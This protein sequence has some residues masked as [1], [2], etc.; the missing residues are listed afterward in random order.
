MN[1]EKVKEAL[2][3][4]KNQIENC[5]P[6]I[7]PEADGCTDPF[8]W[9]EIISVRVR[10]ITANLD[11]ALSALAELEKPGESLE[12]VEKWAE[13][14]YGHSVLVGDIHRSLAVAFTAF[15]ASYHAKKC[16]ECVK[17]YTPIG[18]RSCADYPCALSSDSNATCCDGKFW[19][20]KEPPHAL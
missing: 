20:L 7:D 19:N 18:C 13:E 9:A 4:A 2:E 6:V 15:A 8:E 16:A 5:F 1:T 17:R 12:A 10:S 11:E 3:R 14:Y